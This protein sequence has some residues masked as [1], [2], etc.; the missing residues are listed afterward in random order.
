[1]IEASAGDVVVLVGTSKGLFALSS[2]P[3]R[4]QWTTAGPFFKGEEIYAAALTPGG[5]LLVGATSSHW[6]PSVYRSDDLGATWTEPDADTLRFPESTGAALAR[7][8]QLL[9]AGGDVVFA[10]VEPAAL[11]RSDDGGTTF[12]LDEGLWNHEHRPQWQPG[13]GGLCLHTIIP[14]PTGGPRMAVAVS[15]AGFYRTLDGAQWEAAN[16]GIKAVFLPDPDVEFGQ[17]VHKVDRHPTEPDTLFLQHHWG[18]YRSDDFGGTWQEIGADALPSTFGFP[19][20]VD[21]NRPGT[22]YVLPLEG[23]F[24]RCT[25][26]GRMR[27]YRTTDGGESWDALGNGLPQEGAY[28]TVLRD[29]FTADRLDPA[30]LYFGTRTGEVFG[31]PDAGESWQELARHLPPVLCVKTGILS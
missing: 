7:V 8:W 18:V 29:G 20:V 27:V 16:R 14:D 2:G 13:G 1:M 26:E 28:L 22:A 3:D 9:P 24:F 23:D 17:C 6:G 12:R 25:P 5:R 21:P 11:F 19:V 31:S 4:T 10:G 15:A 30:G